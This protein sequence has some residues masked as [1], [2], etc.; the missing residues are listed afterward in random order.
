MNNSAESTDDTGRPATWTLI[1]V[2]VPTIETELVS[3]LLWSLGVVAVEETTGADS[4]VT[5]LRTSVGE[6][7]GPVAAR[8]ESAFPVAKCT[9]VEVDTSVAEVWREHAQV[10]MIEGPC[11]IVPAWLEAPAD[12]AVVRVEPRDT[13]GL[14][15]HPTTI[16]ALTLAMRH[17]A[18]SSTVFDL[19]T[20]SGILAVAMAVHRMCR[21][22]VNDISTSARDVVAHNASLNGATGIDWSDWPASRPVDAVLANILAPVLIDESTRVCESIRVGGLV[23]LSGMRTEQLEDVLAHYPGC[24]KLDQFIMDGWVSVALIRDHV[25]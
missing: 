15:N 14:G 24:G 3:D 20:G 2:E 7:P 16:G 10:T 13:F 25:D 4:S 6:H 23:I 8:I 21:V 9:I 11:A 19:G 5:V 22:L 18:A 12:C 1:E 17:V